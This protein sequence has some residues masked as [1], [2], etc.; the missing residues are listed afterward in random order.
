MKSAPN[1][2]VVHG[3]LLAYVPARDGF[4]GEIEIEVSRNATADPA[5]DF[6]RPA[7]GSRVRAFYARDASEVPPIGASVRAELTFSGGPSGS[8]VV[9]RA[10]TPE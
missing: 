2:T 10:L 1:L 3:T 5:A 9:A 7:I 8:R 4:G 6:I